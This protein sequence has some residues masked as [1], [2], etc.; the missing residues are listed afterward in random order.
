MHPKMRERKKKKKRKLFNLKIQKQKREKMGPL[1]RANKRDIVAMF[2]GFEEDLELAFPSQESFN[3]MLLFGNFFQRY[4]EGMSS[5]G[6][7]VGKSFR[8]GGNR[9]LDRHGNRVP[10]LSKVQDTEAVNILMT[11]QG[12]AIVGLHEELMVEAR[13]IVALGIEDGKG[14]PEIRKDLQEAIPNMVDHRA[15][16]IAR[17][18][19]VQAHAEG[20]EQT[21][22]VNGIKKTDWVTHHDDKTCPYCKFLHGKTFSSSAPR[23]VGWPK[24]LDELKQWY[25]DGY[26]LVPMVNTHPHCRCAKVAHL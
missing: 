12:S 1:I 21:I 10:Q 6:I 7:H 23:K 15:E 17:S 25:K 19:I 22:K 18:E 16:R 9:V 20:F 2:S 11:R 5:I 8:E 26:N 4:E 14:I 13:A 3:A 24:N